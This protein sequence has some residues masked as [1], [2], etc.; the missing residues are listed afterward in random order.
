MTSLR[1]LSKEM[2]EVR[3]LAMD[4]D[5]PPEALRDTLDG[6]EGMFNEKAVRVVDVINNSDSDVAAI[7]AEIARL[8]ARKKVIQNAQSSLKEYLRDNME[9]TGI[10]KIECPFFVITLAKGRDI[11]VVD[12][13]DA[14]PDDYV[15]VMTTV[16]PDKVAILK[17]LKE[18]EDIPGAHLEK[19]RSSVRIK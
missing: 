19:S 5:I 4:P 8:Q 11:A 7:D 14:L 9:A 3:D 18:G 6:I 17:A 12:N 1:D 15:R 10:N 16:A 2:I 13:E